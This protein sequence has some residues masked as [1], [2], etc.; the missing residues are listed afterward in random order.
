MPVITDENKRVESE[1]ELTS[2]LGADIVNF[3][4]L[5]EQQIHERIALVLN[6]IKSFY[7][8][9]DALNTNKTNANIDAVNT[10]FAQ[11]DSILQNLTNYSEHELNSLM[12]DIE[13]LSALVGTDLV[14]VLS[15]VNTT[16]DTV[17]YLQTIPRVLPLSTRIDPATGLATVDLTQLQYNLKAGNS[18]VYTVSV[19]VADW[20]TIPKTPVT[21]DVTKG[22]DSISIYAR[23]DRYPAYQN[24]PLK[25][26]IFLDVT[27]SF[28]AINDEA[29]RTQADSVTV[30]DNTNNEQTVEVGGVDE[31][32]S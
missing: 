3:D 17:N 9:N 7:N 11:I 31:T 15:S 18:G 29:L 20:G 12:E 8:S 30:L 32:T 23:D 2:I 4:D 1:I 27:L 5:T 6:R 13:E 10:K 14:Q 25:Y 22:A 28:R 26:P 24:K 21:F 19:S 16:A